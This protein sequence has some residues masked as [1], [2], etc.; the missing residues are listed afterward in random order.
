M[1]LSDKRST[2]LTILVLPA[3]PPWGTIVVHVDEA[4]CMATMWRWT[5]SELVGGAPGVPQS[6]PAIIVHPC[7][8]V[9]LMCINVS[10]LLRP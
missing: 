7:I 9:V 3:R 2:V 5:C 8:R 10:L 1:I 6:L 4:R